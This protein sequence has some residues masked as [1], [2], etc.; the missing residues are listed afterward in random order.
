[1]DEP[2]FW[3]LDTDPHYSEKLDLDPHLS[4]NSGALGPQNEAVEGVDAHNG[5]VEAHNGVV[6]A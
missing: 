5:V 4:H 2:Y 1:V 6:E 3:K